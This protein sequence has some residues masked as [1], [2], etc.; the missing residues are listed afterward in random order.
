MKNKNRKT[1]KT[2]QSI[3]ITTKEIKPKTSETQWP[4]TKQQNNRKNKKKQK[5]KKVQKQKKL[6]KHK[7]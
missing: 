5:T 1:K 2:K 3:K 4:T 6:K 7:K